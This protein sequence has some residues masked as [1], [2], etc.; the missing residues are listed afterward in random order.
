MRNSMIILWQ[1]KRPFVKTAKFNP[2]ARFSG[3]D[4]AFCIHYNAEN[5]PEL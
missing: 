2:I 3:F 5:A 1:N 4:Q